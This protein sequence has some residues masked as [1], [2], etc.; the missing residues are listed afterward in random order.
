VRS[1]ILLCKFKHVLGLNALFAWG[2][3]LRADV[4]IA[5]EISLGTYFEALRLVITWWI[6]SHII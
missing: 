1:N 3:W 2:E 5:D 6:N 4:T